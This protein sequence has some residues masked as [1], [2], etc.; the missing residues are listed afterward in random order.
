M[1]PSDIQTRQHAA[2][3]DFLGFI[4]L[5]PFGNALC[6]PAARVWIFVA[7]VAVAIMAT[8]EAISWSYVAYWLA[9][10]P[11]RYA[12]VAFVFSAV[13]LMIAVVDTQFLTFDLHP[14]KYELGPAAASTDARSSR[15]SP[16]A[17]VRGISA[18]AKTIWHSPLPGFLVRVCMVLGS[19]YVSSPFLTQ[20]VLAPD[21]A[22]E[23]KRTQAVAIANG[24]A[25]VSAPFDKRI[26]SLETQMDAL[27][28]ESVREAAGAGASRRRGRGPAVKTVEARLTELSA[29]AVKTKFD[30]DA[31]IQRFSNGGDEARATQYGVDTAMPTGLQARSAALARLKTSSGYSESQTPIKAYLVGV[32]LTILVLKAFQR[33][34][35]SIYFSERLQ[36]TYDEYDS[37]AFDEWVPPNARSTQ[38][39]RMSPIEFEDWYLTSHRLVIRKRQMDAAVGELKEQ[40]GLYDEMLAAR[41]HD[42]QFE[43]EPLETI[44]KKLGEERVSI[45]DDITDAEASL[46]ELK[47]EIESSRELIAGM[48]LSLQ[49][50]KRERRTA[51]VGGR[52]IEARVHVD[53]LRARAEYVAQLAEQQTRLKDSETRLAIL[54]RDFTDRESVYDAR[55][56][57]LTEK[58]KYRTRADAARNEA[59]LAELNRLSEIRR[60]FETEQ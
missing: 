54:R 57:E 3:R 6:S 4:T 45:Q 33:K 38:R 7:R 14:E 16:Q 10:G 17:F 40:H 36:A 32:F 43:L 22:A 26:S 52:D 25:R 29:D 30:R 15:R 46:N 60:R 5:K 12:A 58:E 42:A 47:I 31:A 48:N 50:M 44:I 1:E 18:A 53:A 2:W 59:R 11:V 39:R 20:A 34:T 35:V 49:E 8:T 9:E 55:V 21:I 41:L 28:T 56:R 13:F 37:G 24:M 23:L 27:R 19:L 51:S